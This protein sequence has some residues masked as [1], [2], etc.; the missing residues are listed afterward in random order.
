[1]GEI[2]AAKPLV[3]AISQRWQGIPLLLTVSTLAGRDLAANMSGVTQTWCP[4]DHPCAVGSFLERVHPRALLLLETELWPNILRSCSKAGIPSMLVNGRIS[5]RHFPRYQRARWLVNA[6]LQYLNMAAMQNDEYAARI[7]Q[8]GMPE[9]G[10][11][12]TGSI[13]FDGLTTDVRR[14]LLDELIEAHQLDRAAPLL[15]F[16]STRPGDEALAKQVWLSIKSAFPQLKIVVAPRHIDRIQE[17]LQPFQDEQVLLR[18]EVR[19]GRQPAGERVIFLDTIGELTKFYALATV[20]VV[21][22]SFYPG[23]NGHNPLEPAAL[24]V[25][26]VFGPYMRNFID[27]ARELVAY[28]GAVQVDTP[29]L[30]AGALNMLLQQPGRRAELAINAAKAIAANQGAIDRTLDLV[31][32]FL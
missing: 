32:R 22:G 7:L 6:M 16:G 15:V 23:V 21:G 10:I 1:V 12:V 5:D 18:S 30:L 24:G 31:E 17:A 4:Y 3:K 2:N 26:T 14:P 20:A 29:D 28:D 13:K 27:P 11:N 9:T 8:L 19:N 25:P